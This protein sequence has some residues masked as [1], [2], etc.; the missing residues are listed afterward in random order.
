MT[1]SACVPS[2]PQCFGWTDIPSLVFPT[3]RITFLW[4]SVAS[5]RVCVSRHDTTRQ[6][7][8]PSRVR[9]LCIPD[10]LYRASCWRG[11]R[12]KT[13][14]VFRHPAH[15]ALALPWTNSYGSIYGD[16]RTPRIETWHLRSSGQILKDDGIVCHVCQ[17][18]SLRWICPM[19]RRSSDAEKL[20]LLIKRG[21]PRPT[22]CGCPTKTKVEHRLK[23]DGHDFH[24]QM[25]PS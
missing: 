1:D 9:Q 23:V 18:R 2:F 3:L 13:Y 21:G 5:A 22:H 15:T 10:N 4:A 20:F 19:L 11:W 16:S 12:W 24:F 6:P 17:S 8:I 7:T 25:Q 14:T